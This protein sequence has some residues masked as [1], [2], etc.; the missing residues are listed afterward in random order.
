MEMIIGVGGTGSWLS[1]LKAIQGDELVIV[2]HDIISNNDTLRSYFP[3]WA[4]GMKKG[5]VVAQFCKLYTT[6]EWI[7]IKVDSDNIGILLS[8]HPHKLWD[9]TDNI[10]VQ[11]LLCDKFEGY[12]HLGCDTDGLIHHTSKQGM[13]WSIKTDHYAHAPRNPVINILSAITGL[14]NFGYEFRIENV[15]KALKTKKKDWR[16]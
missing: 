14:M 5:Q 13:V 3:E 15:S 9:C 12:Y 1:L 10:S 4:V 8:M 6:V 16:F 11:K 2:D 7:D